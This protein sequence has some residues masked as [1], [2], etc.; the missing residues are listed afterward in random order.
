MSKPFFKQLEERVLSVNSLLCVGLDPHP[1]FLSQNNAAGA[2]DFCF[3]IIEETAEVACA[4]KPN[5][6][7]FEAFG[8]DGIKVLGDVIRAVPDGIPVI[9]DAKRGDIAS[10][11]M[12][13]AKAAFQVLGADALTI[14]PYLGWDSVEPMIASPQHAC[15]LLCKTSN[16]GSDDFQNQILESGEPLYIHFARHVAEKGTAGNVGLVV[17]ATDPEALAAVREVAPDLWIL[18]PGVGSQ[19]GDLGHAAPGLTIDRTS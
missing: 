16:P 2:R 15:F 4:F 17:G 8:A 9:L 6:A 19:G 12:A 3:R 7:F 11:A 5:S 13:Y 14:N 18:A 10:T 1:G